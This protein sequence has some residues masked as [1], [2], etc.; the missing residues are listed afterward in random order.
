MMKMIRNLFA[1]A[2]ALCLVCGVAMAESTQAAATAHKA[3]GIVIDGK[4]DEWN[5]NDPLVL[6]GG[7]VITLDAAT[8]AWNNGDA[9]YN[10]QLVRDEHLG[11]KGP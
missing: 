5:L 11:R 10:S 4:L 8:A 1:L 3:A 9:E 2:L 6:D 7:P